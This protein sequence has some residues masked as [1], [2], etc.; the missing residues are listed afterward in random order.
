MLLALLSYTAAM[1]GC[2]TFVGWS[3]SVYHRTNMLVSAA[4]CEDASAYDVVCLHMLCPTSCLHLFAC[5]LAL[6]VLVLLF[7][8]PQ[9]SSPSRACSAAVEGMVARLRKALLPG[10]CPAYVPA[11]PDSAKH[12]SMGSREQTAEFMS[13]QVSFS[14]HERALLQQECALL[15]AE[16]TKL[17]EKCRRL[18]LLQAKVSVVLYC[19]STVPVPVT[20]TVTVYLCLCLCPV[21][22]CL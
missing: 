15:Q 8:E 10:Q 17:D 7:N 5:F 21:C 11:T 4:I 22:A 3:V 2:M 6:L 16:I 12:T 1:Y 13:Q 14:R 19:F 18:R 20:L 9:P